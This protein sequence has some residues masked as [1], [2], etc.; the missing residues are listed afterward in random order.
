MPQNYPVENDPETVQTIDVSE[1]VQTIHVKLERED[2]ED[3]L[4]IIEY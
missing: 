1:N 4:E 2:D 3:G